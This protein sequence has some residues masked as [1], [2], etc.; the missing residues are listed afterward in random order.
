M[1][2]SRKEERKMVP[3]LS[4]GC[5]CSSEDAVS[6]CSCSVK[7]AESTITFANRVDHILARVGVN[8]MGHR[9]E[10]GLYQIGTPAPDSRV[11]ASA[12]YT[13]SF[14][15]LR[16]ALAGLDA[17]ILVLDTRGINVWCAAG[18]GTFGT[19]ELVRRIE[20]TGLSDIVSTAGLLF[21]S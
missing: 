12:N 1:K 16:S 20:S 21:P 11:F 8:R 14:D 3:S 4:S 10:P 5:S 18:K 9:V 6:P 19:D 15:A 13:L 7:T 17:Y 2:H